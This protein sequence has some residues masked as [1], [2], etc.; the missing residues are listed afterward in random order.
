[1]KSQTYD[2]VNKAWKNTCKVLFGTEVGELEDFEPYLAE[3]TQKRRVE[4]AKDGSEVV[5]T[6]DFYAHGAAFQSLQNVDYGG[7]FA[8]LSINEV[9]DIDSIADAVRERF[10]YTGNVVLG[11]SSNVEHCGD[12]V[13]SNF[14]YK[15]QRVNACKYVAHCDTSKQGEWMFGVRGGGQA[16]FLVRSIL[17]HNDRRCFESIFTGLSS[18]CF[19]TAKCINCRDCM[20]SFGAQ[21][22]ANLIGNIELPREKYVALKAKLLSEIAQILRKEKRIFS[23]LE[24][25]GELEGKRP[26][27]EVK[28]AKKGKPATKDAIEKAFAS[29]SALIFGKP[30]EGGIDKY[31]EYLQKYV[32]KEKETVS[33]FGNGKVLSLGYTADLLDAYGIEKR[34]VT[35]EEML[36][37]GKFAADIK[38]WGGF[39]VDVKYLASAL[40]KI[41]YV[42]MDIQEGKL[43]NNIDVVEAINAQNCYKASACVNAKNCAIDFWPR[44]SEHIFGSMITWDSQFCIK[45]HFSK[46]M[47]RCLETDSCE[48]CSDTYFAHNCENVNDSMFCF[49]AKNL[50]NAIGNAP[51]QREKY[52]GV[53][54]ALLAQVHSELEKKKVLKIDIYSLGAGK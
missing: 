18:D 25:V 47:A 43:S 30:L 9:K 31:R 51:M 28:L 40:S 48:H 3:Y 21:N 6:N 32:Y 15:C 14:V 12:V 34:T 26:E 41:A 22:K 17:M 46:R 39:K 16:S 4:K 36:E 52:K 24:I 23:I 13:D 19:Y 5:L 38:E 7:K 20:F 44:D 1:M 10:C 37:I 42:E 8:P 49:N 2:A 54:A 27:I 35:D 29:T 50:V 11:N 33:P 53:K 45:T